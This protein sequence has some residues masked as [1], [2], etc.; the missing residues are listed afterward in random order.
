VAPVI[1][2]QECDVIVTCDKARYKSQPDK[3]KG[4]QLTYIPIPANGPLSQIHDF[5]AFLKVFRKV[6]AVV[7]LGVSAG[8]FFILMRLLSTLFGNRLL[9][10]IDGIEWRRTKFSRK[11]RFVLRLF[12]ALAQLSATTIIYDSPDLLP[13]VL[14][15][16]R[17][18]ARYIAYPGDHII[19]LPGLAREAYALTICRIEPENN[20]EMLI[21]G[22]LKSQ[23]PRYVVIGNWNQ[24]EYGRTLR[25]KYAH[26]IRLNLLDPIYDA[27]E[28]AQY[29]ERCSIYLHGHSVGGTNPSLVEMLF[30]DC[31]ILCFDCNFNRS[32][33]GASAEYFGSSDALAQ[34][35]D[36]LRDRSESPPRVMKSNYTAQNIAR[37]YMLAAFGDELEKSLQGEAI[38]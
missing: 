34:R 25:Q 6:D 36:Q 35:L 1:S 2:R 22:V 26:E 14:P 32:T 20:I 18:K 8:F 4:V 24:S 38:G 9:I 27:L 30:Y 23:L 28:I 37:E 13:Y 29:R 5:V 17:K 11:V 19:R 10:N 12:D 33:A 31:F 3:F 15:G 21:E 16:F 7:V